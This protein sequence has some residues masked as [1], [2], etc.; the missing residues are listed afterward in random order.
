MNGN[1]LLRLG[2]I[3]LGL[4][5]AMVM[6]FNVLT[7]Y[8]NNLTMLFKMLA[9]AGFCLGFIQ[10]KAAVY[11]LVIV[12]GYLDLLKRCLLLFGQVNMTDVVTVLSVAPLTF[13]GICCGLLV[14]RVQ[15]RTLFNPAEFKIFWMTVAIGIVVIAANVRA[16]G[17]LGQ[18]LINGANGGAYI[19]FLL[20][21]GFLFP[22]L[23]EQRQFLKF[24]LI[25]FIPVALYALKQAATGFS[26]F[27]HMYLI[28]GLT[29]M[30]GAADE[31]LIRPFS[32]LNS[33]HAF[34]IVTATLVALSIYKVATTKN[35][36]IFYILLTLLYMGALIP[37]YQRTAWAMALGLPVCFVVF[38]RGSTTAA[39]YGLTFAGLAMV[40]AIS[41]W[42]ARN[43]HLLG[44]GKQSSSNWIS[45]AGTFDTMFERVKGFENWSRNPE[46]WSWFG[47]DQEKIF[48]DDQ[49]MTHDMIG[50][51][52]INYG[53]VGLVCAGILGF[54][55]LY[56]AHTRVLQ[57]RNSN[58]RFLGIC[59]LSILFAILFTGAASG[60]HLS[61]FPINFF[62]WFI[63]GGLVALVQRSLA[64]QAMVDSKA[65]K[66]RA[67]FRAA[68]NSEKRSLA[69]QGLPRKAGFN[70]STGL[71]AAA[72][73]EPPVPN[74]PFS[75][76]GVDTTVETTQPAP[77]VA[78][79]GVQ[80]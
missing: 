11:I 37:G 79:T 28:S 8:R 38:R 24:I 7:D 32:T 73:P 66:D 54:S 53:V 39:L 31:A 78:K 44:F 47:L 76:G 6:V 69:A 50:G 20:F 43:V 52:L 59:Y 55:G 42:L 72:R 34:G 61:I 17:S 60:S 27:E 3:I 56:F 41:P 67:A 22:T 77:T 21:V 75:R 2:V 19:P 74:H 57:I 13:A 46:M 80:Q 35:G 70:R 15:Q 71:G 14:G 36:R 65:A 10:P 51:L 5:L 62:F 30:I 48:G 45:R 16:Y 12:C 40:V 29:K 23:R 68:E 33:A 18:G 4:F 25:A 63:A 58:D 64:Q 26:T 49:F 9:G 1:A